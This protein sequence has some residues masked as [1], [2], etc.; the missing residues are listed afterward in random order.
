MG[1][2]YKNTNKNVTL[3]TAHHAMLGLSWIIEILIQTLN[4]VLKVIFHSV[5]SAFMLCQITLF[6]KTF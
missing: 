4:H 6:I 5:L 2:K 3:C 1:H